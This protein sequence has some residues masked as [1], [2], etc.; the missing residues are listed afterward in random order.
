[1]RNLFIAVCLAFAGTLS[2]AHADDHARVGDIA[3]KDVWARAT[4]K[5]APNGAVFM[6]LHS[7]GAADR[8]VAASASVSRRVEIHESSMKDGVMRM[9][10]VPGIDVPAGGMAMLK[11]GGYHVML[12]GL[13]APLQ[14]GDEFPLTLTFET[15][16]EVTVEVEVQAAGG[17]SH[18]KGHSHGHG[19][20][21]MKKE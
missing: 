5:S 3:I 8:L 4:A 1:M 11:P 16:G 18:G 2:I 9:R 7:A 10:E 17:M 15:A 12:M 13:N 19:H 6:T 14:K 21:K 20:G